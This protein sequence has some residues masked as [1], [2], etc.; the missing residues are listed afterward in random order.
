M[1]QHGRKVVGRYFVCHVAQREGQGRR[2]GLAVSRKV[3]KAVVRNRV[4]R[5]LREFFRMHRAGLPED[6]Q[7]VVV[8][9]PA[10][11]GLGLAACAAALEKQM[12]SAAALIGAE[13]GA[14]GD[15]G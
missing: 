3:G 2:L 8:A 1:F 14:A 4:K 7:W 5:L 9:R 10:C 6:T 12:Q 11:A 13:A 15:G